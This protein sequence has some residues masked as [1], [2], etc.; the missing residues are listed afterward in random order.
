M[1]LDAARHLGGQ[2][3]SLAEG[4]DA[5]NLRSRRLLLE[6]EVGHELH[7]RRGEVGEE[8]GTAQQA[9]EADRHLFVRVAAAPLAGHDQQRAVERADVLRPTRPLHRLSLIHI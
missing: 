7:H 5:A 3:R 2:L 6:V 1:G 4:L 9:D 8:D